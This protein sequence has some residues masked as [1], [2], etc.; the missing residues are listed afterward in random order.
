MPTLPEH[1]HDSF[2]H[3]QNIESITCLQIPD[4]LV[5]P[6]HCHHSC[7]A[8]EMPRP[9]TLT[10]PRPLDQWEFYKPEIY[11][12]FIEEKRKVS[13]IVKYMKQTHGFDKA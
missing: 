2:P 5:H 6:P 1:T 10:A 9:K 8:T 7:P 13:E 12:L 4:I 3:L 11:R